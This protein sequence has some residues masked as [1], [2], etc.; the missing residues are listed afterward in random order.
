MLRLIFIIPFLLLL[1]GPAIA[2]SKKGTSAVPP[3]TLPAGTA[4]LRWNLFGILDPVTPNFTLGMEYKY[5]KSWSA[6]M[7]AGYI[8]NPGYYT[9]VKRTNGI[10]LR[11]SVRFYPSESQRGYVEGEL[12][13]KTAT[14][15]VEDWLGRDVV[16][17]VISYEEFSRFK[18]VRTSIGAH[19][20][21]GIMASLGKK[22]N[23]WLDFFLG[24][25]LRYRDEYVKDQPNSLYTG[26]VAEISLGPVVNEN[27]RKVILPSIP[28]GMRL[29]LRVK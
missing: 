18:Y 25:G 24:F 26:S 19:L 16:N 13:F 21:G 23:L 17:G 29:V 15:V 6:G 27:T 7:D 12:H 9:E 10:I 3:A 14:Y 28:F 4:L 8:Y 11:P 1:P 2:Q 5:R 22:Q 20:K